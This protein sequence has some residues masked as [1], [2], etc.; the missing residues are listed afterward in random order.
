VD[1]KP[2][3]EIERLEAELRQTRE[4]LAQA[5]QAAGGGVAAQALLGAFL[6]LP[7]IALSMFDLDMRFIKV[8]P[9]WCTRLGRSE[10]EVLGRRIY[11]VL[12]W[13]DAMASLHQRCLAG[14]TCSEDN[15]ILHRSPMDFGSHRLEMTPW[16]TPEGDIGG[17]V[18]L[19][20]DTSDISRA[21]EAV[22]RS[23]QRLNLALEISESLV[24]E[25]S[26]KEKRLF[27]TGAVS[28]IYDEPPS[29]KAFSEDLFVAVHPEDRPRV[30]AAWKEHLDKGR[31][32]RTEYRIDRRDGSET[33]VDA[34]AETLRDD[35]GAPDR[36]IGVLRN[37][38]QRKHDQI[39]VAH[40][41][42][43]AEAAN[44][45]KSEF[46]AN[47]SH[48]IRT[49]LNGVMGV[50]GALARTP[51][52]PG[53]RQMVELIETS[54]QTLERL[55]SDILDLSRIEAG[56]FEIKNEPFN[57]ADM[58]RGVSALFEPKARERGVGFAL[59]IA[60]ECEGVFIGDCVRL[61][62]ILANLLSNAVKFTERGMVRLDVERMADGPKDGSIRFS[63]EDTGIGFGPEAA[64]R[65][66]ERFEQADGSIT[67]RFG[68]SGLGLAISRS[69]AENMGGTLNAYSQPGLGSVFVLALPLDRAEDPKPLPATFA[70]DA[71]PSV[72][73]EAERPLRRVLLA[74]DHP[75]NR[76]VIE[77]ILAKTGVELVSV[78]NGAEAVEAAASQAF[79]L[80]LMDM[81]MPVM[82]GLTAIRA[83]RA[84]E[85]AEG[86]ARTPI[87][88]LTA[89]AMPAHIRASREAGAGG[90]ITKPVSAKL[91]LEAV[92]ETWAPAPQDAAYAAA[93]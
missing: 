44:R 26:I 68:G 58:L 77:L 46:L 16:T 7:P 25:M 15:V 24:W 60:P 76:M 79:D 70:E 88:A 1:L 45:A 43:A 2:V 84:R 3:T 21:R 12:P 34:V 19:S 59:N 22:R 20:Y 67:R 78:V 6:N 48:E 13:T 64:G 55:L 8:S 9:G 56:R 57:L 71:R 65:L 90:H 74:E 83:I 31:P 39:A 27:A 52:E 30:E 53:Q 62:Q 10:A 85:R 61:R 4:E 87:L 72:A 50:A 5:R 80:I 47:M 37:V 11:E 92:A 86:A 35:D 93:Q 38:T 18:I 49:P 41:R 73:G 14:E 51:L 17:I 40:A 81:Q 29:F 42:E 82:D 33:W 32:F 69:L 91:L 75:A 66:F 63:V 28:A 36:I 54:A 23:E 89:N